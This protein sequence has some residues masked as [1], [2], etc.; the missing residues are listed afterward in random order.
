MTHV[1]DDTRSKRF[2]ESPAELVRRYYAAWSARDLDGMLRRAHPD[3][4]ATPTLGLLY[5]RS[6][7]AGHEGITAWFEEVAEKWSG[8]DPHVD[9]TLEHDGQVIAFVT[10]TA[11][12]EDHGFDATFAVI[13]DLRDGRIV[14][15]NGRDRFEV[16]EE[17]GLAS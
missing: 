8:F 6:A 3:I 14:R 15:L 9:E 7:Y 5:D 10:L 13:H 17:L 4:L 1:T 11:R 2:T 16:L 12:R